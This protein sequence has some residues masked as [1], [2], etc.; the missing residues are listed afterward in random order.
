M[1]LRAK[2]EPSGRADD[3]ERH[4]PLLSRLRSTRVRIISSRCTRTRS[5]AS[6]SCGIPFEREALVDVWY[7]GERIGHFRADFLVASRV[8]VELK[9]TTLLSDA[10]PTATAQLS[11][12]LAPRGWPAAA[13]RPKGSISPDDLHERS[14]A[15]S[16]PSAL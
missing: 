11:A 8:V 3:G 5:R 14:K 13:L 7:K 15:R 1:E 12:L 10:R 6:S 16:A 4:S 2:H 9:A